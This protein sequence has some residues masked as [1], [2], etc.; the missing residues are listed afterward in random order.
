MKTSGIFLIIMAGVLA[1]C[2]SDQS[3]QPLPKI[4]LGAVKTLTAE[5]PDT[6]AQR[7]AVEALSRAQLSGIGTNPTIL[8]DIEISQQYATLSQVA[9]NGAYATFQSGD[10]KTM[11][12]RDGLLVATR[13]LGADLMS[14]DT[15]GT[16]AAL[17]SR[18]AGKIQTIRT[19]RYL[20][21]ENQI[22]PVTYD[23]TLQD[24]DRETIVSINQRFRLQRFEEVCTSAN[25]DYPDYT[26]TYWLNSTSKE[27]WKSRQWAGPVVGYLGV[28][29]LLQ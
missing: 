21:S 20:G 24:R 8:I 6:A 22:I 1:A 19:H 14:L 29:V 4:L 13:G 2:A 27:I 18:F 15:T 5:K 7:A 3:Q 9:E 28:D 17:N 25:Q 10:Q 12:F 26:N 23:C 11:T 16:R